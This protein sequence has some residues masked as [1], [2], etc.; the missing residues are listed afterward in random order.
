MA[1]LE[2]HGGSGSGEGDGQDRLHVLLEPGEVDV[3][4]ALAGG[5]AQR[6]RGAAAGDDLLERLA[7]RVSHAD[8]AVDRE[9]RAMLS[10]DLHSDRAARLDDLVELLRRGDV[11][12]EGGQVR[13]VLDRA[14]AERVIQSLNDLRIGL[15]ATVGLDRIPREDLPPDDPRHETMRLVDALAWLQGGLIEF[16][17]VSR[18]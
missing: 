5:L 7:P 16:V 3:L 2:P 17:D 15:A 12:A 18:A 10:V 13:I 14:R 4:A 8:D 1:V 11:D 9:L 6:L